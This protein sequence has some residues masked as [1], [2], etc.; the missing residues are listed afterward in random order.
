MARGRQHDATGRT[1][2]SAGAC[3]RWTCRAASPSSAGP[4][5]SAAATRKTLKAQMMWKAQMTWR[6]QMT[7]QMTG[8]PGRMCRAPTVQTDQATRDLPARRH[9]PPPTHRPNCSC[10]C[11][12]RPTTS[13]GLGSRPAENAYSHACRVSA[14]RSTNASPVLV[15]AAV[16][17]RFTHTPKD[18]RV[19]NA[20]S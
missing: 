7:A 4:P 18:P 6:A 8:A 11:P 1:T 17:P 10:S 13:P 9:H 16:P 15:P 12:P 14:H 20:P 3:P 5:A 2:C 19:A